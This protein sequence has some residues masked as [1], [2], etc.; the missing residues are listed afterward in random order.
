MFS[1]GL[2]IFLLYNVGLYPLHLITLWNQMLLFWGDSFPGQSTA[3]DW[4]D[5][6]LELHI[7]VVELI[8]PFLTLQCFTIL[9][10]WLAL[11]I[12]GLRRSYSLI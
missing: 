12:E 7:N 2:I 11:T 9:L 5:E 1:G 3:D 8:A 6:E 4:N 10:Q